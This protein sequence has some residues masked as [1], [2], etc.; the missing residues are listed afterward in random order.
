M[1]HLAYLPAHAGCA[2]LAA[3]LTPAEARRFAALLRRAAGLADAAETASSQPA[4]PHRSC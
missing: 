4:L 2:V 3:Q 1:A